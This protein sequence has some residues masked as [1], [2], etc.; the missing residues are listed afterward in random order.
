MGRTTHE[1]FQRHYRN[2]AGKPEAIAKRSENNKARR[3][4]AKRMGVDPTEIKGDV[5]HVK[6]Q[7][8]GGG[9]GSSNLKVV[10]KHRNRGWKDGV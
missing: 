4:V 10:S 1:D 7:R 2:Y 8:S 3:L 6:P 9:N 5:H